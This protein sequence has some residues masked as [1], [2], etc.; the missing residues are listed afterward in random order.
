M[1]IQV[2]SNII[3]ILTNKV[4]YYRIDF[5][6]LS[7]HNIYPILCQPQYFSSSYTSLVF[8]FNENYEIGMYKYTIFC[9]EIEIETGLCN[10]IKED[11]KTELF[12]KIYNDEYKINIYE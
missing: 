4:G 1:K 10:F 12:D 7:S 11:T 8:N 2:N 9:D 3:N 5:E 6:H